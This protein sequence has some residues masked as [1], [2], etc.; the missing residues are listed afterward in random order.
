MGTFLRSGDILTGVFNSKG[1][2]DSEDMV[3]RLRY[4]LGL[5]QGQRSVGML[6]LEKRAGELCL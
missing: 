1:M 2:L 5:G 4:E 3:I 6:G